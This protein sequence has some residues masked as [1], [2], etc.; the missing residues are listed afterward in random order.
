MSTDQQDPFTCPATSTGPTAT[1]PATATCRKPAGHVERGDP[2]H[3]GRVGDGKG[4][5]FYWLDE[6]RSDG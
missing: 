3:E 2:R 4:M 1:G 5:P 6:R